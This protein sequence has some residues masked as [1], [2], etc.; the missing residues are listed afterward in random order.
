MVLE[1]V[2][3]FFR[4]IAQIN[5]VLLFGVFLVFIVVAYKLFQA[6]I[7]AFLVGVIAA[8]FPIVAIFIGLDVPLTISSVIWFAIFGV[9]AYL[10]YATVSS[11]AKI[12]GLVMRPFKGMFSKKPVQ[13]VIIKED[14]K[15]QQSPTA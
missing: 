4:E 7:K 15:K 2:I 14:E 5:T 9:V 8:T 3:E 11:G 1:L 10:F 6:L 12:L 13:K